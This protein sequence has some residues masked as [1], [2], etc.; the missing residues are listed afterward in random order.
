[1][2]CFDAY[3]FWTWK[4]ISERNVLKIRGKYY[5]SKTNKLLYKQCVFLSIIKLVRWFLMKNRRD[6]IIC[7]VVLSYLE[8][9]CQNMKVDD[10]KKKTT[11]FAVLF[12][13]CYHFG[14]GIRN[15]DSSNHERCKK[16]L[17]QA[18]TRRV[19]KPCEKGTIE[20]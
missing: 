7:C 2:K 3:V 6:N 16:I 12:V 11:F 8:F 14:T 18:L 1:M 20:V 13:N 19:Y 5:I 17:W 4:F 10:I 9:F 15:L